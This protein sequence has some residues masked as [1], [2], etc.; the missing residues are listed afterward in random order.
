MP[1]IIYD[2]SNLEELYITKGLSAMDISKTKGCP[3]HSTVY[4]AMK[5]LNIPRRNKSDAMKLAI[6]SGRGN[7]PRPHTSKPEGY[8]TRHTSQ[9]YILV[10]MSN[11]PRASRNYVYEHILVWE[12]VH[13]RPL[14]KGWIVHHINGIKSDN[15][16]SNLKGLPDKKHKRMLT[17]KSQKIRELE[18]ENRLLK[19]ALEDSQMIFIVEN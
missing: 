1:K 5:R 8:K 9:G 11:H 4:S 13:N 6:I 19:K 12:R 10:K 2:W 18:E 16:P 15:R 7:Y 14:P 17:I 3:N